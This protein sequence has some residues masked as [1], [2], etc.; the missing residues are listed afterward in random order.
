MI[1]I[2]QITSP[3]DYARTLE[4]YRNGNGRKEMVHTENERV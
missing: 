4:D 3:S 1:F 2:R